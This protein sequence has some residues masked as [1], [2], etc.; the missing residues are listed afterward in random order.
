MYGG[1]IYLCFLV[2]S[3][4]VLDLAHSKQISSKNKVYKQDS[5]VIP[6]LLFFQQ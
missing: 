3:W 1:H 5:N 6:K 4:S 2:L